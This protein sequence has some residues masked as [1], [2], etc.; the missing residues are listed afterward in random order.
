MEY[1][2]GS[3]YEGELNNDKQYG[4]GVFTKK[5]SNNNINLILIKYVWDFVND[6]KEGKGIAIYSNG[7]KYG[8][9]Y[10][11]NK[12]YGKGVVTYSSWV[13]MKGNGPMGYLMD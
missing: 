3:K 8:G 12:Q 6:K 7:D 11:N 10:K 13:D 5:I 2:D 4:K 9:K 1:N